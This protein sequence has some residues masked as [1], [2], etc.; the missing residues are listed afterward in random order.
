MDLVSKER[1]QET[2]HCLIISTAGVCTCL[3]HCRENKIIA[4]V[5]SKAIVQA[6]VNECRSSF[7]SLHFGRPFH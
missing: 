3:G 6:A 1:H 2:M 5:T 4:I 7:C